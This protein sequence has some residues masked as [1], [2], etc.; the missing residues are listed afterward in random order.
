MSDMT[1][2][3]HPFIL[4][5]R[6]SIRNTRFLKYYTFTLTLW[7]INPTQEKQN[8]KG[9]KKKIL[10]FGCK[11]LSILSI[12]SSYRGPESS[13]AKESNECA[14]SSSKLALNKL[15]GCWLWSWEA[16]GFT[17]TLEAREKLRLMLSW[18]PWAEAHF[19][20]SPSPSS[21]R[22]TSDILGRWAGK[23]WVQSRA[24]WRISPTSI[25][26]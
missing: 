19:S 1:Y 22:T 12:V 16:W 23:Y 26:S 24:T 8:R 2:K 11:L 20:A 14:S 25:L 10:W 4:D 9:R 21:I 7:F 3:I 17:G 13:I 5:K 15:F 18:C 6:N